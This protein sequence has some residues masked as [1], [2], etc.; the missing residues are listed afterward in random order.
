MRLF[1][2]LLLSFLAIALIGVLVVAALANWTAAREVRRYMFAG[3]TA[4]EQQLAQGLAGY[5]QGHGSWD[6]V[7]SLLHRGPG[8]GPMGGTG[9]G[10]G[11]QRL[12]VVDTSQQV[13]GDNTE[14]A[15]GQAFRV[16][17]ADTVIAIEADGVRIGD[18]IIQNGSSAAS[19]G[20][21]NDLLARVNAGIWLAALVAGG[22]ALVMAALIAYGLVRP[23]QQVTE[24][25]GAIAR[26]DLS[27]RVSV[28]S[29]DEVGRLAVAFNAMATDLEK[30]ERLRRD[31]TA[32]V[33][34][35]L[36]NPLAVLQGNLEAV[37]DGVLPPTSENLQ[38][39]LD[40][41]MLLA[42]LVED[43]RTLSLVEAGQLRLDRVAT[44]PA[45]VMQSVITQFSAQARVQQVALT[46]DLAPDL[47]QLSLDAQRITQVL[48]NLLSNALRHTP[49]GQSI[50]CRVTRQ[51]DLVTFAVAD[52]GTGIPPEILAHL[53]ERFYRADEARHRQEGGTGLGLAIAK[54]LVELHGGQITVSSTVGQGTTVSVTLPVN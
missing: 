49:A 19:F 9:P 10:L 15:V 22:V 47:P 2:K 17:P 4:P 33:A 1:P 30:G 50:T 3:G 11:G 42:R 5:Y 52:T 18:L 40:Q 25:A 29:Q 54:Q 37:I 43:L 44:D 32:D 23:I 12:I 21:S 34:H 45:A 7:Q 36:R 53:F 28:N 38:P 14:Q 8:R 35:E 20:A 51:A 26:G 16:A 24:A 31:M 46:A 48:G 39:L 27:Q 13:V 41:T 6:G